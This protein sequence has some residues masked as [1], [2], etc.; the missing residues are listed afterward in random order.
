LLQVF[1]EEGEGIGGAGLKPAMKAA[2]AGFAQE[3]DKG[4]AEL[5]LFVIVFEAELNVAALIVAEV[6]PPGQLPEEV[7]ESG[8]DE[9]FVCDL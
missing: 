4:G 2:G 6:S 7:T 8:V 3:A 5:F 1:P 9:P